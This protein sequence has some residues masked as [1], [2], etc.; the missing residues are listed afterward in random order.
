MAN[1]E[2]E[3]GGQ[4]WWRVGQLANRGGKGGRQPW[5]GKRKVQFEKI[6]KIM[7]LVSKEKT[8]WQVGINIVDDG[9]VP[10]QGNNN[11]CG[12]LM[13]MFIDY[14]LNIKQLDFLGIDAQNY[15][16]NIASKIMDS[17]EKPFN[18]ILYPPSG[19]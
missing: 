11:D 7:K 3:G 10:R 16:F 5:T 9:K 18:D 6:I 8:Q 4:P 13:L 1:R 2:G 12:V 14:F 17:D 15:R 19:V